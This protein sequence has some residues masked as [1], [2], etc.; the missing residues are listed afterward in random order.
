VMPAVLGR[1]VVGRTGP[2]APA[3]GPGHVPAPARCGIAA[4]GAASVRM[5][6]MARRST[7]ESPPQDSRIVDIDVSSEMQTSFLEY[8]YSVIYT[9]A[10]PR[11]RAGLKPV[12]RG[13]LSPSAA[14][15]LA[16]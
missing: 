3:R 4:R 12:P 11:A 1:G 15:G 5:A 2:S 14:A 16:P 10:L 13:L 7:S 6:R 8:A 9:R